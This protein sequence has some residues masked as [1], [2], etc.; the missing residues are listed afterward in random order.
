[1]LGAPP[2]PMVPVGTESETSHPRTAVHDPVEQ[3]A[4][5]GCGKWDLTYH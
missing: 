2:A 1:M 4:D 3:A 5:V